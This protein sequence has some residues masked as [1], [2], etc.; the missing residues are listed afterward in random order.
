ML[1]SILLDHSANAHPDLISLI[2][3]CLN[4]RIDLRPDANRARK[5]TD[6]TLKMCVINYTL[7][8]QRLANN[9]ARFLLVNQPTRKAKFR[10]KYSLTLFFRRSTN[11]LVDQMIKIM[12]QVGIWRF[13]FE[14]YFYK[15]KY[16]NNLEDMVREQTGKLEEEQQRVLNFACHFYAMVIFSR[17]KFYKNYCRG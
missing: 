2:S 11:S 16:T 7:I 14:F 6:A 4:R 17:L 1:T 5:I 9:K 13:P 12:E 8:N 10:L 3:N 15:F